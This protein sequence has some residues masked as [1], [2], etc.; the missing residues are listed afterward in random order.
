M[1]I[2]LTQHVVFPTNDR[3]FVVARRRRS[4]TRRTQ[5]TLPS[6]SPARPPTLQLLTSDWNRRDKLI[7]FYMGGTLN[8]SD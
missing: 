7:Y 5:D 6:V 1:L 2:K 4:E 3:Q 8:S